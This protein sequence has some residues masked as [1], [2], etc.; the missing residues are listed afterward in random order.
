MNDVGDQQELEAH[1]QQW[2]GRIEPDLR[3]YLQRSIGKKGDA[4]D[5][6]QSTLLVLWRKFPGV[7][8]YGYDRFRRW[9][10]CVAKLERLRFHREQ[11]GL[12]F[13][14][15]D[16]VEALVDQHAEAVTKQMG[17]DV[18]LEECLGQLPKGERNFLLN[19]YGSKRIQ[20][21]AE[22]A[23]INPDAVYQRLSRLRSR[24]R[25]CLNRKRRRQ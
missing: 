3:K 25:E 8:P 5:V 4:E 11:R 15:A 17:E 24:L 21:F 14:A 7:Y 19:A 6:L 22:G 12:R 2:L 20:D 1:F 23:G 18:A 9:A 13:L 10:F 16:V